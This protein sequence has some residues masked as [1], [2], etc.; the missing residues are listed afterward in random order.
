MPART[1]PRTKRLQWLVLWVFAAALPEFPAIA[2]EANQAVSIPSFAELE[3]AGAVIGEINVDAQDIFDLDDPKE[4]KF[5]YRAANALHIRTR[6]G[7]IRELLLFKSGDRVSVHAIE[8]TERLLRDNRFIYDVAILPTAY[9]D[10]IVDIA[11][12]TRDTW[13]LQPGV[14]YSRTGG[15]NTTGVTFEELNFLG[16]GAFMGLRNLSDVDRHGTEFELGDNHAFGEWINADY[17]Y[18]KLSDGKRQSFSLA[19]PFYAM[20]TRWSAGASG[21]LNDRVDPVYNSG[22]LVGQ[23]T[24]LQTQGEVFGGWSDGLVDGWTRR[25]SVGLTYE[26]DNYGIDQTLFPPVQPP[27]NQRL[28]APYFRYEVVQDKFYKLKNRDLIERPEYFLM[29]F[30]TSVQIGE[31]LAWL[32]STSNQ[33]LYDASISDGYEIASDNNLLVSAS[34]SGKYSSGMAEK[35]LVSGSARYYMPESKHTLYFFSIQGSAVTN[36]DI[37]EQLML[38][39]DNGLRGYPLRYQSGNKSALVNAERRGYTDWYPF[40]LF[41]IGGAIFY[42]VGRAWGDG[43]NQNVLNPGWLHDVGFGLRILSAR[44]AFGNVVHADFA[45]PLN[46]EPNIKSFQFLVKTYSSF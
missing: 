41:R 15:T 12:K 7:V 3:A 10:G 5:L 9:H 29:G 32:G 18:A 31:A 4:N 28:V 43:V 46:R 25:R 1:N 17:K 36:P 40:N 13:S 11:V 2:E 20:D 35:H 33:W 30:Q 19:R 44:S 21:S 34:I 23:Y 22:V 27:P 26:T 8:E 16:T 14:R 39:G 6:P 38:G 45:F 42:D 37:G 24:H